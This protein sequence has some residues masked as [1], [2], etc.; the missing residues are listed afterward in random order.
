MKLNLFVPLCNVCECMVHAAKYHA[1]SSCITIHDA[2]DSVNHFLSVLTLYG[3][4]ISDLNHFKDDCTVCARWVMED[5]DNL[6]LGHVISV[7]SDKYL[8]IP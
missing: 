5:S 1:F 4:T 8:Y 7:L 2:I 3:C 6:F